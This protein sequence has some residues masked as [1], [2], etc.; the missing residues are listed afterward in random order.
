MHVSGKVTK[1]IFQFLRADR[2]AFLVG[3]G[4]SV[5]V[6]LNDEDSIVASG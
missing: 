4:C 3:S 1:T 2:T 6:E 5:S